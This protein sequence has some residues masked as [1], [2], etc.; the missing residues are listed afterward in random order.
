MKDELNNEMAKE[1]SKVSKKKTK[2]IIAVGILLLAA[3][4]GIIMYLVYSPVK[5]IPVASEI[6]NLE[7]TVV[8]MGESFQIE[9]IIRSDVEL[10]LV[11]M[12]DTKEIAGLTFRASYDI[13]EFVYEVSYVSE[14]DSIFTVDEE[15]YIIPVGPGKSKLTVKAGD[16]A[17][18][19]MIT[20]KEYVQ[21]DS[22]P[23]EIVILIDEDFELVNEAGEF[24]IMNA[25]F[26]VSDPDIISVNSAG[27]ITGINQGQ[28]SVTAKLSN[29]ETGTTAVKVLQP[30]MDLDVKDKSVNVGSTVTSNVKLIPEEA[31]YGTTLTYI[32]SDT[33]IATVNENGVIRGKA[34][35]KVAITVK[36]ENGVEKTF[37]VTVNKVVV[38]TQPSTSNSGS[39]G[40]TSSTSSGTPSG[41]QPSGNTGPTVLSDAEISQ[42]VAAGN[43]AFGD[44]YWEGANSYGTDRNVIAVN[45]SYEQVYNEV[46]ALVNRTYSVGRVFNIGTTIIVAYSF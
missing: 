20:I 45:K 23:E 8:M 11:S 29:G 7:D 32:S 4:V 39:A 10:G 9:P 5:I 22:L 19:V 18:E 14:N 44:R 31:D 35:G 42:I 24:Q 13:Q 17:E 34:A 43:A 12:P 1:T 36:S 15:G 2:S 37:N 16:I 6:S 25:D 27:V 26:M 46:M 21:P 30:V 40:S 41:S 33:G 28:A 3:I 38:H